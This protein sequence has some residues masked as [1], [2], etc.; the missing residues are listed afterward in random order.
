MSEYSFDASLTFSSSVFLISTFLINSTAFFPYPLEIK[1]DLDKNGDSCF[2]LWADEICF[3]LI[4]NL[5]SWLGV[6]YEET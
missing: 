5:N 3:A 6:K 2:Y 4:Y 1:Y